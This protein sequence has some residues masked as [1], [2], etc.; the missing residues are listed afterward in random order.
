MATLAYRNKQRV[1]TLS[2]TNPAT[3]EVRNFTART[4]TGGGI[5]ANS[6][7]AYLGGM[8]PQV[9]LGGDPEREDITL[10]VAYTDTVRASFRWLDGLTGSADA[11]V[12]E[13]LNGQGDTLVFSGKL[14]TVSSPEYDA[15]N[16]DLMEIEVV[17]STHAP[18]A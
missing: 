9:S 3:G 17:I 18:I 15:S 13:Q 1:V 2:V 5:T 8:T 10:T 12:H 6:E 11:S 16:N 7:K 4:K 14:E